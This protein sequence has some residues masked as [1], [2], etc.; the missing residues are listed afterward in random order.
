M[1]S[2]RTGGV[3]VDEAGPMIAFDIYNQLL[4]RLLTEL[5]NDVE[6][7]G[8]NLK[9]SL[10]LFSA[11]DRQSQSEIEAAQNRLEESASHAERYHEQTTPP[12]Y[13]PSAQPGRGVYGP[14]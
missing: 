11:T 6:L 2:R 5:A 7:G 14:I 1:L 3:G 4:V 9:A 13:D 10:E 12:V 8:Y